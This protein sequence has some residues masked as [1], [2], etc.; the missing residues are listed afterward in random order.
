MPIAA[1]NL[2][3]VLPLI[4]GLVWVIAQI[5]GAAA[6]KKTASQS[7]PQ[8]RR[9]AGETEESPALSGV[10]G[11]AD[12]MRQIS[13]TQEIKI[14][15]RPEPDEIKP[16]P[17]MQPVRQTAPAPMTK[18]D[19][20]AAVDIRPTLSA[21][22][23]AMPAMKLPAMNL[24]FRTSE[25]SGSGLPRVGKII[26]P[27]DRQTLRRAVLGHIILGKPRAMENWNSGTVD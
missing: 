12:L 6:K 25:K 7:R 14:P 4:V 13:G 16:Q 5:A 21:F 8:P 19:N 15:P 10:D 3:G 22:R 20:V 24:S 17:A 18:S 2:D 9:N 27:A 11:F 26:N 1:I 23:T